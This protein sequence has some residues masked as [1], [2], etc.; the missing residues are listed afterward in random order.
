[1]KHDTEKRMILVERKLW[2]LLVWA[3]EQPEQIWVQLAA[4]M[5]AQAMQRSNH[6]DSDRTPADHKTSH[7]GV[8][9]L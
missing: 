7:K 5:A 1:M 8:D 3:N 4:F 2:F 9:V 6:A